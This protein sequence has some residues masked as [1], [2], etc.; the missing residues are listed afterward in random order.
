MY[1]LLVQAGQILLMQM[2]VPLHEQHIPSPQEQN[3]ADKVN[4]MGQRGGGDQVDE[5]QGNQQLQAHVEQGDGHVREVQLV[6]HQL[7]G[8]LAVGLAQGL[9]QQDTMHNRQTAVHAID[10]QKDQP[11][12]V[13]S[14]HNQRS[15]SEQQDERN[16]HAAHIARK[17][18]RLVS[19]AEVEN[20]E[21][22][23]RQDGYHQERAIDE[24][25]GMLTSHSGVA[26]HKQQRN[27]NGQRIAAREKLH[28]R[29]SLA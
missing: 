15:N 2:V 16:A 3:H 7:V 13:V 28:T 23:H 25:F 12:D 18:L 11:S 1:Y 5:D 22:L 29:E 21:H 26:V 14:L 6:R 19:G 24:W 20:A 9:V 27:Q 17:A 4:P 10:N 8:V